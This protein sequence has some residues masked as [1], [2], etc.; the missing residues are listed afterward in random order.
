MLRFTLHA[1]AVCVLLAAGVV[2]TLLPGHLVCGPI[3][4]NESAAISTLKNIHSAQQQF[5]QRGAV[6]LDCD[7]RGEFGT[8]LELSGAAMM[9]ALPWL[10]GP[11]LRLAPPLL[12]SGF[13]HASA[14]RV[15][16]SGYYFQI[17]LQTADGRWCGDDAVQGA[18]AHWCA[19]AWPG[20]DANARRAFFVDDRGDVWATR[21]GDLHYLGDERA[22]PIDAALPSSAAVAESA[23]GARTGRDGQAWVVL[24]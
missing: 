13:S 4:A 1:L 17:W 22:V 10:G 19:Y 8:F 21:N 6:D 5:A 12:S 9:R 14:G 24:N 11:P 20:N 7:G 3:N 16:R 15:R 23:P 2:A 18:T